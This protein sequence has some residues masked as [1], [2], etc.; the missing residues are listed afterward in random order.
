ML[1]LE[2]YKPVDQPHQVN[3]P[4]DAVGG[5]N[6]QQQTAADPDMTQ[7]NTAKADIR[8]AIAY[9]EDEVDG[10]DPEG[11][12]LE[13][14]RNTYNK[15]NDHKEKLAA[16]VAVMI[17]LDL[18]DYQTNFEAEAVRSKKDLIRFVRAGQRQLADAERRLEAAIADKDRVKAAALQ[19][20]TDQVM[21][22]VPDLT[23]R[24]GA[25]VDAMRAVENK[26]TQGH[27]SH[28]GQARG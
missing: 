19:I 11:L 6:Q 22:M 25:L 14:V 8:A 12:P 17:T 24:T 13:F 27:P 23:A 9:A 3:P 21:M 1:S 28:E 10:F 26:D 7:I 4:G 2:N 16:G 18:P 5:A 20:K 15:A